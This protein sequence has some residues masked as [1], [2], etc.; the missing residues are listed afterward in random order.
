MQCFWHYLSPVFADNQTVVHLTSWNRRLC[1]TPWV[2]LTLRSEEYRL[3]MLFMSS[4]R[5]KDPYT[6]CFFC[7]NTLIHNTVYYIKSTRNNVTPCSDSYYSQFLSLTTN[8]N[9]EAE[10]PAIRYA[11]SLNFS[12]NC[13]VNFTHFH[14]IEVGASFASA[15]TAQLIPTVSTGLDAVSTGFG[16]I[17]FL[18]YHIIFTPQKTRISVFSGLLRLIFIAAV[19]VTTDYQTTITYHYWF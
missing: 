13:E 9:K 10:Y 14:F 8:K 1:L 18:T 2:A 15:T 19:L 4:K 17:Q 16:S 3:P 12:C 5:L 7:P 6:S 11:A